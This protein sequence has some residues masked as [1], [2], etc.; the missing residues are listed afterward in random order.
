MHCIPDE[1][2]TTACVQNAGVA[3]VA[4]TGIGSGVLTRHEA[5]VVQTQGGS[6]QPTHIDL[7]APSEQHAVGVAEEDQPVGIELA[8]DLTGF[9][10]GDAVERYA[11]TVGL[12]KIDGRCR[13]DVEALPVD[14]GALAALLYAK[15]AAGLADGCCTGRDR[16]P[17]RQGS[18]IQRQCVSR[19]QQPGR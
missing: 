18:G 11:G 1:R 16:T 10:A 3:D 17:T 7:A 8:E 4:R 5:F 19:Q 6:Q 13:T 2:N 15:R 14:C 12:N 9:V